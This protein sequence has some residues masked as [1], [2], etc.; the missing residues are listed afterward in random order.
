M[1][2]YE[3]L[4]YTTYVKEKSCKNKKFKISPPTLNDGFE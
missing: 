2:L 3:I 4:A 1:L